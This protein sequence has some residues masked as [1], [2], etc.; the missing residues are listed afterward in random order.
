MVRSALRANRRVGQGPVPG[1]QYIPAISVGLASLLAGLPIITQNGWF[2]SFAFLV[3]IAWRL[4]RSDPFPAWWAAPLGLFN[5]CVSGL[6]I[7]FSVAVWTGSMLVL[8]L[9]DRRTLFRDYWIEWV[10]ATVLI[11]VH[12]WLQW[13]VAGWMDAIL[14]LSGLVP[15]IVISALAFPLF[16][17]FVSRLDRWRLGRS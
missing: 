17:W 2:P 5:D 11:A 14:P 6:P 9:A 4:L 8:D 3:L 10:L 13:Q 7:G 12:S 15:Q 16:A 1:A